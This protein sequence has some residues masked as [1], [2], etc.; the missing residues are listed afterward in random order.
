MIRHDREA[1]AHVG[2]K[3]SRDGKSHYENQENWRY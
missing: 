2:R 3:S 1:L